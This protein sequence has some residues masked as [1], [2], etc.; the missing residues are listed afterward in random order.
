V[1]TLFRRPLWRD[2][3][4]VLSAVAL[5]IVMAR[6]LRANVTVG[7]PFNAE[8][9]LDFLTQVVVLSAVVLTLTYL[10]A[11]VRGGRV[12]PGLAGPPRE[13]PRAGPAHPVASEPS[14]PPQP[15][16][17]LPP[18]TSTT[19]AR[20]RRC[21]AAAE[22]HQT[23]YDAVAVLGPPRI[24][25]VAVD[26]TVVGAGHP[27]KVAWDVDDAEA[28]SVDE[29]DGLPATG[30]TYLVARGSKDVVLVAHN[31]HGCVTATLTVLVLDI[32]AVDAV[33]VPPPPRIRL[34]A[35]VT[36]RVDATGQV[37]TQ[38]RASLVEPVV[39]LPPAVPLRLTG[40]LRPPGG[41]VPV[42]PTNVAGVVHHDRT[43]D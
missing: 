43:E 2:P 14:A 37:P 36:A 5:T 10:I 25:E 30:S 1:S 3:L 18:T 22:A 34:L 11:A 17:A 20:C 15:S 29:V 9:F 27:F 12:A 16:V 41:L 4:V 7:A 40:P 33:T 6:C 28:V 21:Q 8:L 35:D 38:P 26:R 23:R 42:P 19:R 13:R 32:P 39:V 31:A 24:R